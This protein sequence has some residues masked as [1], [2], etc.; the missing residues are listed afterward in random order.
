[1]VAASWA[2]ALSVSLELKG[3]VVK[4][5]KDSDLCSG[6]GRCYMLAS[7]VFGSDEEGYGT[8]KIADVPPAL[9]EQARLGALNCPERA[10]TITE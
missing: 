7:D 5:S 2:S 4:V 6:H 10:I 9:Q 3:R 8:V 1:M